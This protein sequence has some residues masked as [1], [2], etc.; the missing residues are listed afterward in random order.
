MNKQKNINKKL[1]CAE[2][3]SNTENY[4]NFTMNILKTNTEDINV[5]A[6]TSDNNTINTIST[7]C[8]NVGYNLSLHSKKV[9]V[10]N[11]DVFNP[12]LNDL[13]CKENDDERIVN[14]G[15]ID[16]ILPKSTDLIGNLSLEE[17]KNKYND[18]DFIIICVPSPK[19]LPAYLA[20]C[21]GVDYYLLVNKFISSFYSA[22]KCIKLIE[23]TGAKVVGSVYIKL[24]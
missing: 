24:T 10:I 9:L 20:V 21:D 19:K 6:I 4:E 12:A 13:L 7:V 3:L 11:L 23:A 15:N 1:L 5:I 2:D 22:N 14:Y 18:Y 16:L 8:L 17:L